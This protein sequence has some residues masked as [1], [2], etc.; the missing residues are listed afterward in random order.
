MESVLLSSFYTIL[1]P[2]VSHTAPILSP[3]CSHTASMPATTHILTQYFHHSASSLPLFCPQSGHIKPMYWPHVLCLFL[4]TFCPH[5]V[6]VMPVYYSHSVSILLHTVQNL[7]TY[8]Y[9]TAPVPPL[10]FPIPTPFC[11]HTAPFCFLSTPILPSC[12]H[13]SAP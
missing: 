9:H 4:S 1:S 2:S 5:S 7:L 3:T 8:C 12:C 6:H 10:F 13:Y 11:P